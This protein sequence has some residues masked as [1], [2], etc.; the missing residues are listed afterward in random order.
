MR[1]GDGGC[2]RGRRRERFGEGLPWE[3]VEVGDSGCDGLGA[4]SAERGLGL[5]FA[6]GDAIRGARSWALRDALAVLL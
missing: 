4:G 6:L 5:V 2:V 1:G 3:V